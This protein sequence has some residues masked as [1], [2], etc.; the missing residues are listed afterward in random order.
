[1][2]KKLSALTLWLFVSGLLLAGCYIIGVLQY[3]AITSILLLWI[4]VILISIMFKGFYNVIAIF[5]KDGHYQKIMAKYKLS[6]KEYAFDSIFKKE[7]KYSRISDLNAQRFLGLY[8]SEIIKKV[9]HLFLKGHHSHC[10][11]TLQRTPSLHH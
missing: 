3:W 4:A 2:I 8:L 1:M 7:L 6:R 5:F 10:V 11:I 9:N